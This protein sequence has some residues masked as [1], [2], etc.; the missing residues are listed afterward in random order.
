MR[1]L[2][3]AVYVGQYR[4]E[5]QA[6]DLAVL[7]DVAARCETREVKPRRRRLVI[8]RQRYVLAGM[9][10]AIRGILLGSV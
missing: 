2:Y 4:E 3:H 6:H 7:R 10:R 8:Y 5:R 1:F 9:R